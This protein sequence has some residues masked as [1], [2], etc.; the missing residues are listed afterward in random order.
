M[1]NTNLKKNISVQNI[2]VQYGHIIYIVLLFFVSRH[3]SNNSS[4]KER[5]TCSTT[6]VLKGIQTTERIEAPEHSRLLAHHNMSFYCT[7]VENYL[8]EA[9]VPIHT[10][11]LTGGNIT[12]YLYQT[13]KFYA[14]YI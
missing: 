5:G 9:K 6:S 12:K 1:I 10:L 3:I 4:L 11:N 14:S 8:Y 7:Y 13:D 2:N